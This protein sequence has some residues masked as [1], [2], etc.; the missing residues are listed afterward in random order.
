MKPTLDNEER[1]PK[2]MNRIK[3]YVLGQSLDNIKVVA[4]YMLITSLPGCNQ[5]RSNSFPDTITKSKQCLNY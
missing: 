3:C 2:R 4:Y 1:V 5:N